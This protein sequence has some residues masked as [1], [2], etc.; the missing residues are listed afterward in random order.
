MAIFQVKSINQ[1][2]IATAFSSNPQVSSNYKRL[3]RFFRDF[4]MDTREFVQAA[5]AIM[6][7][8]Q[9]LVLSNYRT[10]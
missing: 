2:Q 8:S 5:I 7:G 4:D 9:K 3:Q 6:K 10:Q 1:A